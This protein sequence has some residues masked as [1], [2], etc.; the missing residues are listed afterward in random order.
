MRRAIPFLALVLVSLAG[1]AMR[2]ATGGGT[3]SALSAAISLPFSSRAEAHSRTTH[4]VYVG[5][6]DNRLWVRGDGDTDLD[7]FVYDSDGDLVDSD[8]DE[9][10]VCLLDTPG[11]GG[12]TLVIRNL[13]R[14][15]N[16]YVVTRQ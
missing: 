4:R 9:S 10:D 3:L 15:Y 14:V 13:G 11:I 5:P 1:I 7:C 2:P 8:T 6:N 16:R 12:H